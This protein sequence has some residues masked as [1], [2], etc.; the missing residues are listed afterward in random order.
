MKFKINLQEVENLLLEQGSGSLL[1]PIFYFLKLSD[2]TAVELMGRV[3]AGRKFFDTL[4]AVPVS[5]IFSQLGS[6]ARQRLQ[7]FKTFLDNSAMPNELRDRIG[8]AIQGA[9]VEAAQGGAATNFVLKIGKIDGIEYDDLLLTVD[10]SGLAGV[11]K[12][13]NRSPEALADLQTRTTGARYGRDDLEKVREKFVAATKET[14]AQAIIQDA[15]QILKKVNA[16]EAVSLSGKELVAATGRANRDRILGMLDDA[17]ELEPLFSGIEKGT[18]SVPLSVK[19]PA[20]KEMIVLD[21]DG[22]PLTLT[23]R[24]NGPGSFTALETVRKVGR[25]VKGVAG[26][27]DNM[28]N[29]ARNLDASAQTLGKIASRTFGKEAAEGA[30]SASR[31]ARF[32]SDVLEFTKDG[33]ALV[34]SKLGQEAKNLFLVGSRIAPNSPMT[35]NVLNGIDIFGS[36]VTGA[37]LPKAV[38]AALLTLVRALGKSRVGL[39]GTYNITKLTHALMYTY[40]ALIL[41]RA[42]APYM[43]NMLKDQKRDRDYALDSSDYQEKISYIKSLNRW[44]K[45]ELGRDAVSRSAINSAGSNNKKLDKLVNKAFDVYSKEFYSAWGGKPMDVVEAFGDRLAWSP[46][47]IYD[48]MKAYGEEGSLVL[49]QDLEEEDPDLAAKLADQASDAENLSNTAESAIGGAAKEMRKFVNKMAVPTAEVDTT[50]DSTSKAQVGPDTSTETGPGD[51]LDE[52]LSANNIIFKPARPS[53]RMKVKI[54]DL[55]NE[56]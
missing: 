54:K 50:D 6:S 24:K 22:L 11:T 5:K 1:K 36:F 37:Y 21:S 23:I 31:A 49:Q 39:T 3:V 18:K 13:G 56:D 27:I 46:Y 51:W 48:Q 10:P 34:L 2:S 32:I 43:N 7:A 44:A 12:I 42:G 16:G 52:A 30:S 38:G 4:P 17:D 9:R 55:K 29:Q 40:Y 19:G 47:G 8:E 41:V 15:G 45:R 35:K 53:A 20:G 25:A 26:T 14:D 33:G 28:L